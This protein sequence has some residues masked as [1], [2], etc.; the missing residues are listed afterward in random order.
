MADVIPRKQLR[1]STSR[2]AASSSSAGGGGA[3]GGGG[4]GAAAVGTSAYFAPP[5][6]PRTRSSVA[7]NKAAS[8]GKPIFSGASGSVGGRASAA[9]A[10]AAAHRSS[11]PFKKRSHPPTNV[12]AGQGR[13]QKNWRNV[14]ES[15]PEE[16]DEDDEDDEEEEE[17]EEDDDEEDQ[18]GSGKG[19]GKEP[20][21]PPR[22]RGKNIETLLEAVAKEKQDLRLC[23]AESSSAGR[24]RLQDISDSSVIIL[25]DS[26]QVEVIDVDNEEMEGDDDDDDATEVSREEMRQV[27][28]DLAQTRRRER[29]L[30]E[31]NRRLREANQKLEQR[32]SEAAADLDGL[33]DDLQCPVC[34]TLPRE[35]HTCPR[36]H[37]LCREC[38]DQLRLCPTC[39]AP[40]AKDSGNY[41]LKKI[42]HQILTHSC[43][44]DVTGC[45]SRVKLDELEPHEARCP[46]RGV[47]C[48]GCG[49][50]LTMKRLRSHLD[51]P[52][53]CYLNGYIYASPKGI[54]MSEALAQRAD[55]EL[56]GMVPG[57]LFK[58]KP[59]TITFE[60]KLCFVSCYLHA[61]K[62]RFTV[63]PKKVSPF[64][65]LSA[66]D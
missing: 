62:I 1:S 53:T 63:F 38:R 16:E 56:A 13:F 32:E 52:P 49:V 34:L 39:R 14:F 20:R 55:G 4:G 19:K 43:R 36:G 27:R 7:P 35:P 54:T 25:D 64:F 29:E 44:H 40:L 37:S 15:Q 57:T 33:A 60:E 50:S 47:T 21:K 8:V 41:L 51:G 9:A 48:P 46:H 10:A 23:G 42:V 5:E 31:E 26:D 22:R 30:A 45:P 58:W 12:T 24:Q 28:Q 17:E 6:S 3:N 18:D 61:G 65:F 11:Q 59:L 2:S 66:I